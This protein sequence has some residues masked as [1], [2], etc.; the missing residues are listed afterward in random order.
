M[1]REILVFPPRPVNLTT[2]KRRGPDPRLDAGYYQVCQHDETV[3]AYD[4]HYY[5]SIQEVVA[6]LIERLKREE[7]E[8]PWGWDYVVWRCGRVMAAIH[9]LMEDYAQAVHIFNDPGNDPGSP[10]DPSPPWP[11]R[12]QWVASGKGPLRFDLRDDEDPSDDPDDDENPSD[13]PDNDENPRR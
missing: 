12:A 5:R 3:A 7:I 11:T 6:D 1:A 8:G 9:P 10:G 13:D 4:S 2:G